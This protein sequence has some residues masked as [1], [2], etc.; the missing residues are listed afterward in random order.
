MLGCG[1]VYYKPLVEFG[2][3]DMRQMK[4]GP[5]GDDQ[6]PLSTFDDGRFNP[7]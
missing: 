2:H 4:K 3:I 5:N 7:T 1:R 6:R